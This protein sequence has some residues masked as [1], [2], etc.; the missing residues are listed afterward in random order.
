MTAWAVLP[1][2]SFAG[3]KS[4]LS[5]LPAP[6]RVALA[7]S[8]FDHVMTVLLDCPLVAGV[9]VLTNGDDVEREALRRGAE[10]LRDRERQPIRRVID[11]GLTH[12]AAR[13]TS[14]A[15]VLMSDLPRLDTDTVSR[16]IT[17]MHEHQVVIAPDV[18][19]QG[20]NALGLR[21]PDCLPTC[22]GNP[23]SLQR[24]LSAIEQRG[25]RYIVHRDPHIAFDVDLPADF[26][27]L[28]HWL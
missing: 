2:K 26:A 1:V 27:R 3:A 28:Q 8:L 6:R 13:N 21:P 17:R 10:V 4:R 14:A 22:F 12:L 7:R 11:A 18:R 20:T 16:L 19:E 5:H 23:D 9:L 25:L 24:H 15:L